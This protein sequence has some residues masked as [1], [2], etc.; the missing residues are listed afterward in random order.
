MREEAKSGF[1]VLRVRKVSPAG[2]GLL[3]L[4][5]AATTVQAQG[6]L[7]TN[8][9]STLPSASLDQGLGGSYSRASQFTRGGAPAGGGGGGTSAV[10]FSTLSSGSSP[11]TLTLLKVRTIDSLHF[12]KRARFSKLR[13]TT[14]ALAERIRQT[15]EAS[16][17]QVRLRF[18]QFI[19]PFPIID[20]P[21]FGYGFFSRLD[22]VEGGSV[23][24][25]AL[26]GPFTQEVQRSLGDQRFLDLAAAMLLNP[27]PP[28]GMELDQFYDTQLAAL[29]NYLF[30]NGQYA[31]AANAWAALR[32]HDST[33]TVAAR[34][35]GLCELAG[36]RMRQAAETLRQSFTRMPSWPDHLRITGSSL[37]DVFPLA[38]DLASVRDELQAQLVKQPE[39]PDLNFL[40]AFL[41]LFQ[42]SRRAAEE[43]LMRLAASD[44]VARHLLDR[45]K[46]GA[47]ADTVSRPVQSALRR[48][49]EEVTGLEEKPMS[50][51]ARQRLAAIL[52]NGPSGYE[53]E[54]RLG[55]FRF[56]M[57]DYTQAAEDYR[58]AHKAKPEDPFALFALVH[59]CFANGEYQQA[60]RY[61]ETALALEPNWGLYEFRFQE[62]YGDL[63][64][65]DRQLQNLQ[66]LLELRPRSTKLKFLLAYVYYFSGRY[67]EATDLLTEVLRLD[68]GF[69][70]A[71][72][73]L[74][75]AR[76]QG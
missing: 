67:N 28:P 72:Y 25:E 53:D 31:A 34:A 9:A 74:R 18:Q 55:D 26:L 30:N 8:F 35:L 60:E 22:L 47:V 45:L 37:G 3:V 56:F 2:L 10:S 32:E 59:A 73:F 48:V 61:L 19:F 44:D 33:N 4:L 41:D 12:D 27:T 14:L 50:P 69:E 1:G 42:G 29:G 43:R 51:E 24:P 66:R 7:S 64:E 15:N 65:Y 40:M 5:T 75:L 39:D 11:A 71:G 62:F 13:E 38:Q 16:L 49:A 63:G 76:L 54:M 21:Q 58:A 6:N 52:Q 46:A 68:P 57:G 23:S 17:S 20:Q 36:G 70:Q